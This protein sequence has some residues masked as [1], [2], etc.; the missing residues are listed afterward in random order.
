[1]ARPYQI[2]VDTNVL[3]AGLRSKL[4]ASYKF[5]T[6]LNDQRWQLNISIALIFEY[7]EVLKRNMKS[8]GLDQQDVDILLD[9][10]CAIAHH[11]DI[12]YLWRPLAPDPNDDFLLEL[13]IEAQADFIITYNRKDLEKATQFGIQVITPKAFLQLIGELSS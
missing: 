2:V 9:G 11:R 7:E 8:L 1:M 5:L 10:V 6:L 13:A 3:V 12:F 4:G